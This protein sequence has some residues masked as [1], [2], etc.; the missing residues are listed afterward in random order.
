MFPFGSKNVNWKGIEKRDDELKAQFIKQEMTLLKQEYEYYQEAGRTER[1][2]KK[3][4]HVLDINNDGLNDIIYTGSTGGDGFEVL[5]FLNTAKG[6]KEIFKEVQYLRKIELKDNKLYRLYILDDGC[7]ADYVDFNKI[8]QLDYLSD[9][10]KFKLVYLTSN[11]HNGYFPKKYFSSPV[12]FEVLNDNYKM[13]KS[14]IIDDT[15]KN[16]VQ[17]IQFKG[18]NI[19]TLMKGTKGRA[20]ASQTDKTGRVW[21]LVEIDTTYKKFGVLFYDPLGDSTHTASKMGWISSRFVKRL[22]AQ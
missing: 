20:I 11:L 6:F 17:D 10:P 12:Y 4:C 19:D 7:C 16:A 13:R 21:W 5:V 15:T 2:F 18:N 1:D 22:D 9:A 3:E 14:P 8:Y